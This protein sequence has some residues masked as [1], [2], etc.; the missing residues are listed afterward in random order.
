MLAIKLMGQ[1]FWYFV[2]LLIVVGFPLTVLSL[3]PPEDIPEEIL[4]TEIITAARSP[5]DG[6]PLTVSEYATLQEKLAFQPSS[7]SLLPSRLKQ[8]VFLLRIRQLFR[9]VIPL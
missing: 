9:S 7:P 4:R 5:L 2:P 6:K 3:P 8:T 1:S